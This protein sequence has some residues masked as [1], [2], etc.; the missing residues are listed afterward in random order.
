MAAVQFP[1]NLVA[2]LPY[3]IHA[4][5][6]GL[7]MA[8]PPVRIFGRVCEENAIP[9][10]LTKIKQPW[11]NGQVERMNRMI[12]E[13]TVQRY[14]CDTHAELEGHLAAFI[15]ACNCARRL[16]LK[17]LRGRTPFEFICGKWTNEPDRVKAD[18]TH[19]TPGPNT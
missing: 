19:H 8:A 9:L 17:T 16:K 15:A 5:L 6:T 14:H 12:K 1:G 11:T 13:A 18:P 7:P 4:V 3:R 10:R 2:A